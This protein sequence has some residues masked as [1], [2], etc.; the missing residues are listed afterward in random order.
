MSR[1]YRYPDQSC[2]IDIF[3]VQQVTSYY[4]QR[5]SSVYLSALDASKAFDRVNHSKLFDKLIERDVPSCFIQVLRNWYSKQ[6]SFVRWNGVLS[7]SFDVFCGV[8]QGGVLSPFLFNI[9]VDDLITRLGCVGAGCNVCGIF[10]GCI[11]YA[12]DLLL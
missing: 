6:I 4:T 9:Y 2:T 7:Q 1:V 10:F 8:R 3:T 11:I 5:G 12:D